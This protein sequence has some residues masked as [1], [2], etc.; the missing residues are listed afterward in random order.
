VIYFNKLVDVIM[1]VLQHRKINQFSEQLIVDYL[2]RIMFLH[3]DGLHAHLLTWLEKDPLEE[4]SEDM[5]NIDALIDKL[6]SVSSD[7]FKNY[8]HQI[9]KH[10]FRF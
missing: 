6:C 3:R 9:H 4:I 5:T 1:G 10:T 2:K 8:G 7:N